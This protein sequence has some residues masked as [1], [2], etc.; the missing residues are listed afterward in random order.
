MGK[1]LDGYLLDSTKPLILELI[2]GVH[3]LDGAKVP[4]TEILL[5]FK[6]IILLLIWNQTERELSILIVYK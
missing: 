2:I 3:V 6:D 5:Y 1:I 4:G